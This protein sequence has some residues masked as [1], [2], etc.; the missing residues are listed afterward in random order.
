MLSSNKKKT[1]IKWTA[2]TSRAN[3]AKRSSPR[4]ILVY[5]QEDIYSSE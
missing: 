5:E 2:K 4:K 3:A 1:G